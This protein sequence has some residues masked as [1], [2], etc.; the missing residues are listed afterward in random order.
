LPL[1]P[2]SVDMVKVTLLVHGVC[3]GAG[4]SGVDGL[5]GFS[6]VTGLAGLGGPSSIASSSSFQLVDSTSAGASLVALDG[7][8]AS[9]LRSY[10]LVPAGLFFCYVG[11]RER[12]RNLMSR[13]VLSTLPSRQAT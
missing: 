2:A 13:T 9:R 7:R 5:E 4:V 3:G 1:G 11:C 8:Y 12:R 10:R 6:G